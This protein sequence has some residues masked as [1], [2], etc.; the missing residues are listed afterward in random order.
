[1]L[2]WLFK[3]KSARKFKRASGKFLLKGK[4]WALLLTQNEAKLQQKIDKQNPN[5]VK[6]KPLD[7]Q[8]ITELFRALNQKNLSEELAQNQ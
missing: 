8:T 6:D 4:F 2:T 7:N 1:M 3:P 5:F